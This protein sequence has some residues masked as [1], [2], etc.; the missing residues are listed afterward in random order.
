[1]ALNLGY[2]RLRKMPY[3]SPSYWK[4]RVGDEKWIQEVVNATLGL[5]FEH[6]LPGEIRYLTCNLEKK[7]KLTPSA[8]LACMLP[9]HSP[10]MVRNGFLSPG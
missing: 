1:M 7:R 4:A 10:L 2:F 8:H 5:Q 9:F 3:A 6:E